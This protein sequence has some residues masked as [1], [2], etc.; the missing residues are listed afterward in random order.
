MTATATAIRTLSG[1]AVFYRI[2]EWV[3]SPKQ[4][5]RFGLIKCSR[6]CPELANYACGLCGKAFCYQHFA[7]H[8]HVFYPSCCWCE[9]CRDWKDGVKGNGALILW[10]PK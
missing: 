6:R 10:T 4:R 8:R 5:R 9:G 1:P 7:D 2:G 3:W